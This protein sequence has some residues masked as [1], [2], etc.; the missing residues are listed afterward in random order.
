MKNIWIGCI[1]IGLCCATVSAQDDSSAARGEKSENTRQLSG[2]FLEV[3]HLINNGLYKNRVAISGLAASLSLTERAV[4][5]SANKKQ[6]WPAV[7]NAA[8]GFG[9]GS[10]AQKD[11]AGGLVGTIGDTLLLAGNVT[12]IALLFKNHIDDI[13]KITTDPVI[14]FTETIHREELIAMCALAAST[15]VFRI[16]QIVYSIIHPTA[17]NNTLTRVLNT[18]KR[19]LQ[20][21]VVSVVGI[22]KDNYPQLTISAAVRL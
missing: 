10:W 20:A 4:L 18:S 12:M 5:T 9:F 6:K 16:L 19:P 2:V 14:F 3:Q 11:I 1:I 21:G 22:D 7:L 8:F 17:Y 15:V 13:S